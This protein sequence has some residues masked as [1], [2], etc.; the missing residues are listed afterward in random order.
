MR[1]RL[2]TKK[3]INKE[4][5][6]QKRK[7]P[8]V[9]NY[10]ENF[11]SS[12]KLEK[13]AL[14]SS[15]SA[16]SFA[17]LNGRITYANKAFLKLMGYKD[18]KEILGRHTIEFNASKD[19]AIKIRRH[20]L[21]DGHWEG[22]TNGVRKDGSIFTAHLSAS[23]VK[24]ENNVPLSTMAFFADT[25]E[26]K[27]TIEAIK[28]SEKNFKT[29]FYDAAEGII[30][31]DLKT[32]KFILVNP[33]ICKMFG[34]TEQE[35]I[36][37]SINQLHPKTTV[38]R[39]I[40]NLK[41]QVKTRR[42]IDQNVPCRK[43]DGTI[44]YVDINGANVLIE[45]KEYAAGFFKDVTDRLMVELQAQRSRDELEI[46]VHQRTSQ[47]ERANK[48]L[49]KEI[50]QRALAVKQRED[51]EKRFRDIF[52]NAV[53]G[54][55]RT[56]PAGKILMANPALVKMLGYSSFD[57][58]KTRDLEKTGFG[59]TYPR[60]YFKQIMK[61]KGFITGLESIW[62]KTDGSP[63][64]LRESAIAVKDDGGEIIYYEG[65]IEDITERKKAEEQLLTY[66]KQLRSLALELSLAEE[67]LRRQIAINIHDNLG[68]DLAI[69]KMKLDK[70]RKSLRR[71]EMFDQLNE[72]RT[73]ISLSIESARSLTFEL[74]PPILYELGFEAAIQWL[75]GFV[76]KRDNIELDFSTDGIK[77]HLE[78]DVRVLLFQ[79]AREILVNITKHAHAKKITVRISKI[80]SQIRV[81][82]ADDGIGFDVNKV[83]MDGIRK[84]GFGLFSVSERL[85]YVGGR[86]EIDSKPGRGTRVLLAAPLRKKS[87][88]NQGKIKNE[89]D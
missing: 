40:K 59:P 85:A 70:L 77:K 39:I 49:R 87:N 55:Y 69:S 5:I 30:V 47:L 57:E 6:E 35:M 4:K 82:I 17:D 62:L 89:K 68:Q 66:Q 53:V 36:K 8:T 79:S 60:S 75:F 33:A 41:T 10:I 34:Y 32:R 3:N 74:S 45:G 73:L 61:Q 72:I 43:K 26:I 15:I 19:D 7:L 21:N 48:K 65:T 2:S 67:R 80:N 9:G 58:L 52:E 28:Q 56:T 11:D 54:I 20:I 64:V 78:P 1:N 88:Q 83:K 24:D 29:L 13:L 81:N 63:I 18:I 22:D 46:R 71:G 37:S 27:N 12:Y 76:C 38:P 86:F 31:V 50:E 16:V 23:L 25:T 42:T 84:K 51:I 14:E 44:F